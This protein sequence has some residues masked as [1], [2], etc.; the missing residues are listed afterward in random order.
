MARSK[1]DDAGEEQE[2]KETKKKGTSKAKADKTKRAPTAYNLFIQKTINELKT[3]HP[4]MDHK[5]R[6]KAATEAWKA[7]K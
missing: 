2:V 4:E 5:Q 7:Q 6:F 1:K 3:S